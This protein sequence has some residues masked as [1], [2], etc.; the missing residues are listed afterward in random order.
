MAYPSVT[1]PSPLL[2]V[3][4]VT[5]NVSENGGSGRATPRSCAACVGETRVQ[6]MAA[7]TW[8]GR[9]RL[10]RDEGYVDGVSAQSVRA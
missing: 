6:V 10:A 5:H 8:Q 2:G 9:A 3:D 4:A 1:S 7:N